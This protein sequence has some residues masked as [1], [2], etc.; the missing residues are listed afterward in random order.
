MRICDAADEGGEL[1]AADEG[2]ERDAADEGGE[3]PSFSLIGK[4]G[5]EDEE[6][7]PSGPINS[8]GPNRTRLDL[9]MLEFASRSCF[10]A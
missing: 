10:G 8:A 4:I 2:G 9:L 6:E 7:E 3:L 1:D 5:P